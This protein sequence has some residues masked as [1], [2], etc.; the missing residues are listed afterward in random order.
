MVRGSGTSEATTTTIS[1]PSVL[2][3]R[4]LAP[5]SRALETSIA[6]KCLEGIDDAEEAVI[7]E[8]MTSLVSDLDEQEF[9][10]SRE[11]VVNERAVAIP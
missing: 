7:D 10:I 4:L 11:Q 8:R 3:S 1:K 2:A 6:L 9:S 5:V